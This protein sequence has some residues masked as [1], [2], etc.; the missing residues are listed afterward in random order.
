MSL[1][2]NW[3][4]S[5]FQ[6]RRVCGPLSGCVVGLETSV[7]SANTGSRGRRS[8]VGSGAKPHHAY[9]QHTSHPNNASSPYHRLFRACWWVCGLWF[10]L[11]MTPQQAVANPFASN[12]P[13]KVG[14]GVGYDVDLNG[15]TIR[16]GD[17]KGV[18][19]DINL[20]FGLNLQTGNNSSTTVDITPGFR[21]LFPIGSVRVVQLHA[22][23]GTYLLMK[24]TDAAFRMDL[25]LF[26]GLMPEIFLFEQL[27]IEIMVGFA[28]NINNIGGDVTLNLGTIGKGISFLSGAAFHWYF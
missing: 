6:K 18:R 14:V 3:N 1:M 5:V 24:P 17:L 10:F 13:S 25:S 28:F 9:K 16:F 7:R 23:V 22:V 11:W 8:L 27:S 15:F 4:N 26:G 12:L 21:V 2:Q 20:G 19:F